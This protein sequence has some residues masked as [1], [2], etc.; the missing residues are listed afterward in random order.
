MKLTYG[1]NY[2]KNRLKGMPS[3]KTEYIIERLGD[4]SGLTI[5]NSLE[6][7][8]EQLEKEYPLE[9][10]GKGEIYRETPDPED[11]R[12]LIWEVL[13]SGHKKVVWHF[14]GWHWD[15]EEFYNLEQG[16]LPSDTRS[17]YHIALDDGYIK[18]E[19]ES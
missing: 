4:I 17:L 9:Y 13:P 18:C 7:A 10:N 3:D 5:H 11:D 1:L 19:N 12:I 15:S 16:K 14:S 8:L 2:I 6:E